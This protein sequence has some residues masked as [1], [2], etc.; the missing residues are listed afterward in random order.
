MDIETMVLTNSP[1]LKKIDKGELA[2]RLLEMLTPQGSEFYN[3]P[4][5]C[6]HHIKE[7]FESNHK[8]IVKL[9]KESNASRK[10][11]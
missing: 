7:R 6:Y 5:R 1:D 11:D 9:K 3:D 8:M 4:L 10:N 2:I